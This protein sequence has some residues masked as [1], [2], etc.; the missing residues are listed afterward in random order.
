[1][2]ST[3]DVPPS[4]AQT[5]PDFICPVDNQTVTL[6]REIVGIPL[7][8]YAEP[9]K[10]GGL[11]DDFSWEVV[12]RL[13]ESG[14]YY[15]R[16]GIH[17]HVLEREELLDWCNSEG[18][19]YCWGMYD[20]MIDDMVAAGLEPVITLGGVPE[21][22]STAP[23]VDQ[24]GDG[25]KDNY[26]DY[27]PENIEDWERF[28]RVVVARYQDR[29]KNWEIWNEPDIDEFF[30]AT[31][32]DYLQLLNS[33]HDTIKSVDPEA[34]VWGPTTVYFLER[35]DD[36][37]YPREKYPFT[38]TAIEEGELDV[39]S[40]HVYADLEESY[41]QVRDLRNKLDVGPKNGVPIAITETNVRIENLC[42]DS[43]T[44]EK[45]AAML[46]D[47]YLC[48]K[49][50]GA[51]SVFWWQPVDSETCTDTLDNNTRW[52][53]LD[54]A[55]KNGLFRT[56]STPKPAFY[57]LKTIAKEAQCVGVDSS[58]LNCDGN[59][60]LLDLLDWRR[61]LVT[62]GPATQPTGILG[63]LAILRGWLGS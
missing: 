40:I 53:C 37:M 32:E 15:G 43:I 19:P 49:N 61:N 18:T 8:Q 4:I 36:W 62:G 1:M 2:L 12:Q 5:S 9:F 55:R 23:D 46:V 52:C 48:L 60:N 26:T 35:M 25:K 38:Q 45:Q 10:G 33:A 63:Y 57:A 24:D 16:R 42:Y 11:F 39:F 29:V 7:N 54:G 47:R 34:K 51:R 14:V 44:E 30:K 27:P 3:V 21:K 56:D 31:P 13:G 59:T 41:N 28:V 50:A 6:N 17:W 58:D 20:R 22:Y